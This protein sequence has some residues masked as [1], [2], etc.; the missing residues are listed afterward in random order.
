MITSEAIEYILDAVLVMAVLMAVISPASPLHGMQHKDDVGPRVRSEMVVST[1]WLAKHLR[2][3]DVVV[4]CIGESKDFYRSGHVPGARMVALDEIAVMRNGIPHELPDA[5]ILKQAFE[6]AG[7]SNASRVILYGE[8]YG[9]LA[10]RAYFTLDYLGLGNRAAL[11]DGGLEKWKA[12]RRP[13]ST[14]VPPVTPTNLQIM[15]NPAVVLGTAEMRGLLRK[16]ANSG[17]LTVIDARPPD[18]FSGERWSKE[19]SK[20]GHIPDAANVYWMDNLVSAENPVL[21][22]VSELRAIYRRAGVGNG[23]R[24]VTYCRTGMQSS[25]DYFVAKYLGYQV[26]MYDAS[27]YEW[28]REGRPVEKSASAGK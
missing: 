16:R 11:L 17:N 4:L 21:K 26:S 1:A 28:S 13:L 7:V 19:V 6:R 22:P 8:R 15:L 25:F 12:E 2:D 27:F 3:T 5:Q 10:A 24:V 18:E 9:Q 14:D 20:A 23:T